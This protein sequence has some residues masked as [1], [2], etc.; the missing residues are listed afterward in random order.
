MSDASY[1]DR[2]N[3]EPETPKK[4]KKRVIVS[5]TGYSL[6]KVF[7]YMF[8]GLVITSA[9]ALGLGAIFN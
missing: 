4:E 7:L 9:I 6:A 2:F 3:N 1:Y 5:E 8:I